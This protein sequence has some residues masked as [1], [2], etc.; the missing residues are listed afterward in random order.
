MTDS[1]APPVPAALLTWIPVVD[2]AVDASMLKAGLVAPCLPTVKAVAELEVKGVVIGIAPPTVDPAGK[3]TIPVDTLPRVIVPAPLA[4]IFKF[5]SVPEERTEIA[6]PPAAAPLLIF[7]PVLD[8]PVLASMLK[9]GFVAPFWPTVKAVAEDEVIGVVIGTT[10]PIVD[11]A[12]RITIPVAVP[13]IVTVPVP[14]ASIL[15]FSGF[16]LEITDIAIPPPA[17]A[18]FKLSPVAAELVEESILKVGLVAP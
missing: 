17:A 14:L 18:L 8:V 11:P 9:A 13:L 3:M 15:R 12:G 5:S 1:A 7:I 4:S 16:P 2:K 6:T 10:P